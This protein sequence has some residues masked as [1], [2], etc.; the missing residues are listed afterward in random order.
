NLP[1]P[2]PPC[3]GR[4]ADL[5][6][7]HQRLAQPACRLLTLLGLGGSGKTALALAAAAHYVQPQPRT[8]LAEE[9]PFPDGIFLVNLADVG[10]EVPPQED[11]ATVLS[12]RL[13]VAIGQT[14]GVEL[15]D[16]ADPLPPLTHWLQT[17]RLL[18]VLDSADELPD[19]VAVIRPIV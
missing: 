1:L 16:A 15:A 12:R 3:V 7:L 6:A 11:P 8:P 13:A 18:L 19:G 5:A 17:R 14:L 9:H 4:A 10:G 2:L